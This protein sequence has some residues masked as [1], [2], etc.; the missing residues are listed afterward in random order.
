MAVVAGAASLMPLDLLAAIVLIAEILALRYVAGS[1][2]IA[3][4]LCWMPFVAR[5][6]FTGN[7][8]LV[9][10]AL[11]LAAVLG[12]KGA[13]TAVAVATMA[14]VSPVLALGYR[15]R[16]FILGLAVMIAITLPFL[17]LW[18]AW[19]AAVLGPTTSDPE[20]LPLLPRIPVV[21]A[22]L[23]VRRPWA[24]AAAAGLAAPAF[25]FHSMV[26]LI[27]ACRLL[28][29]DAE[30]LRPLKRSSILQ[31]VRRDALEVKDGRVPP[32]VDVI[33]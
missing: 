31:P 3:G 10:S 32:A 7:L 9:V 8:N 30:L 13:G 22:L 19:L 25:Y 21:V 20:V 15:P 14:K 17:D 27:P 28:L 18:P 1:W 33:R 26:L 6:F 2:L 4:L 16:E 5:E 11:I 29:E 24:Y 12:R 23:V